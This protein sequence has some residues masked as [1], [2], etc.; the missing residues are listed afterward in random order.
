METTIRAYLGIGANL[1]ISGHDNPKSGCLA[2]IDL[3]VQNTGLTVLNISPWYR[4]E[5]VPV[6]DQPWFY[7][8]VVAIETTLTPEQ[9][10]TAIHAVETEMGRVRME[11]NEARVID[12]DIVD[13]AG[14]IRADNPVLPHPRM[15]QRAFVLY[16]LRDLE[17]AWVHPVT[18][19]TLAVLISELDD[20]NIRPE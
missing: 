1:S 11:R 17:P 10:I 9:L 13:F 18:K 5:P 12:I 15:H 7:N 19:Q 16:P 14:Q 3:L 4:T 8:A 6:S 2:A 20:Q